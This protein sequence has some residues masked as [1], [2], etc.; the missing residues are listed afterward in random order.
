MN[1]RVKYNFIKRLSQFV[2]IDIKLEYYKAISLNLINVDTKDERKV[3]MLVD[4]YNFLYESTAQSFDEHILLNTYYL[5][6]QK[7]LSK[8]IINTIVNY[9]Y[10]YLDL[11]VHCLF[12]AARVLLMNYVPIFVLLLSTLQCKHCLKKQGCDGRL[13]LVLKRVNRK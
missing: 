12:G 7:R 11:S 6:T 10:T 4:A 1:E 2:G 13:K 9:Y 3:K 5:V 8:K